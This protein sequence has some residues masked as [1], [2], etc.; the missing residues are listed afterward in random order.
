MVSR[1]NEAPLIS[2]STKAIVVLLCA[3]IAC[4]RE[5]IR[6]IAD[7]HGISVENSFNRCP[8]RCDRG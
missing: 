2:P 3:G 7:A 6:D 4:G 8:M 1:K 5:E